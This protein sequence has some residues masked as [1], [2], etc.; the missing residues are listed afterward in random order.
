MIIYKTIGDLE[1]FWKGGEE[2]TKEEWLN[3]LNITEDQF[4]S[5]EC[6]YFQV[7][8]SEIR[9][10]KASNWGTGTYLTIMRINKEL[11][12]S[13]IDLISSE[14]TTILEKYNK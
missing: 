13:E 14:V 7:I 3:K 5:V 10:R 6:K 4:N 9:I 8:D 11:T 1:P 2:R 12:E